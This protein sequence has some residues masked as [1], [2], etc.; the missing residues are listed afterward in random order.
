[1]QSVTYSRKS[2]YFNATGLRGKYLDVLSLPTIPKLADDVLYTVPA[3]YKW[4]PDLLSFD[5]YNTSE[6]WWVFAMRNP[7]LIKDPVFDL[8][9]GIQIYI[10]KQSNL[11][12]LI[13]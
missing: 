9:P 4:R 12:S 2:P 13:G 10:P 3:S 8:V 6:L 1:M 11:S 7:N 5:L